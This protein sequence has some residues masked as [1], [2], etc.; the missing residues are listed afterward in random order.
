MVN[1]QRHSWSNRGIAFGFCAR[2]ILHAGPL[3]SA[4]ARC[5]PAVRKKQ[6]GSYKGIGAHEVVD[7]PDRYQRWPV[8]LTDLIQWPAMLVTV[9][10]AWFVASRSTAR[11][12][13]GFWLFLLSNVL[14]VLW[15]LHARAYALIALQC[16]LA[17]TNIRGERRNAP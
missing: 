11:R 8:D 15:G 6:R 3:F 16:F 1:R 12:K 2:E 14:W 9:S 5:H 10:A 7:S 13:L 4:R 17:A